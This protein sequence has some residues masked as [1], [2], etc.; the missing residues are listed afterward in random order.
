VNFAQH[1]AAAYAAFAAGR[2][3]EAEAHTHRVLKDSP[4]DP[5]A[6]TLR[7]RLALVAGEPDVAHDVF[8]D[9]LRRHAT[10][11][12]LWV[13]LA[14]ALRDLNYPDKAG[15]AMRQALALDSRDS[16]H[17]VRLG[18]IQ[19]SLNERE[20]AAQ[21]FRRAL[22]LDSHSVPA[23]RGLAQVES[24]QPDD[25]LVAR[26]ES[27]AAKEKIPRG[28]QAH[29]HYTLAQIFKRA[30]MNSEFTAHLYAANAHQRGA[31]ADDAMTRYREMFDRIETVFAQMR[32]DQLQRAKPITPTPLFILGMPRSGTTL[33]ERLLVA[34]PQV[35]A[36]GEIDYMRRVLRRSIERQTHRPFPEGFES[37]PHEAIDDAARSFGRRLQTLGRGAPFVTDKTPGNYHLL[38]LLRVLFPAGR[39]VH[40]E[41]DP[42][43]TCFS[44]LQYPFD[45]RSPHT[46]DIELLAYSYARYRT[47]MKRWQELVGDEY[48]TVRY[49]DLVN[50][51]LTHAPRIFAHCGL[52]WRDE[53]VEPHAAPTPVR[54]FSAMQVRE[55]I[56]RS[57]VG[58]WRTFAKELAPLSE[59][60]ERALTGPGA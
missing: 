38:G 50:A 13:D 37:L 44:I 34:H 32:F 6:L 5:A 19:V 41:R 20:H 49:E 46:C 17:W 21:S 7:G 39:I 10:I 25:A 52:E 35:T 56:Y 31:C 2:Y 33:V 55:P 57:S 28:L 27:L 22:E 48:L 16:V 58:A 45:E 53:Y 11:P 59:A 60:L 51:P 12:A 40:V 14:L 3:E 8:R 29:L 24:L 4:T 26:F 23:F 18:E 30:R 15:E 9:L 36:G 43:D 54:T 42:M 47:L 1:I